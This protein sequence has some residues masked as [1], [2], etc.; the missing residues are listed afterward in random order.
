MDKNQNKPNVLMRVGVIIGILIILFVITIGIIKLV[1]KALNS[2]AN[3]RLSFSSLFKPS[4]KLSLSLS[5]VS[6]PTGDSTTLSFTNNAKDTKG[7]YTFSYEC[8]NGV[9]IFYKNGSA[10][11]D[12]NCNFPYP[13]SPVNNSIILIGTAPLGVTSKVPL[14]LSFD[15]E[16]TST[17]EV[18]KGTTSLTISNT[19]KEPTPTPSVTSVPTATPVSTGTP[20]ATPYVTP[21]TTPT[22]VP[23]S[24][25]GFADLSIRLVDQGIIDPVSRQFISTRNYTAADAVVLKFQISNIGTK[26]TGAWNFR[27]TQPMNIASDYTRTSGPLATLLPGYST[28]IVTLSLS[29]I[30]AE[31]GVVSIIANPNQSTYEANYSNNSIQVQIPP[32]FNGGNGG[33]PDLSVSITDTGIV[34]RYNNQFIRTNTVNSSDKV[35]VRFTVKNIGGRDTGGWTLSAIL[36]N[37]TSGNFTSEIQNSLRPG[38]SADFSIDFDGMQQNYGNNNV[39]ITLDPSN[40]I[41]ESNEGN[42]T[43]VTYLNIIY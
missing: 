11:N 43:A 32:S 41:L 42:N 25:T 8:Q 33:N 22:Y 38:A 16:G 30:R 2:L 10:I 1:P 26:R 28:G 29:G 21:I 39:T 12:F 13:V 35:R 36:P 5:P 6:I 7:T 24:E 37:S 34:D 4:E 31:G 18:L 3:I 15:P 17:T 20:Q 9:K 14:T 23:P 19:N 40:S 27:T